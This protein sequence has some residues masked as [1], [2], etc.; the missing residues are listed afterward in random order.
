[1]W[2][3]KERCMLNEHLD[4]FDVLEKRL[5]HIVSVNELNNL[6]V[7]VLQ[8]SQEQCLIFHAAVIQRLY[9]NVWTLY[10]TGLFSS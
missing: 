4:R 1:M 5:L 7:V 6:A 8:I 9:T 2:L 10:K 3:Y